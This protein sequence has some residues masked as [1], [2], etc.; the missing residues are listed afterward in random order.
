MLRKGC[1]ASSALVRHS[2][3][4]S[5]RNVGLGRLNHVA[6]AVP[7]LRTAAD[8]YRKALGAVVSEPQDLPAHG[9]RTVFV[10]LSNCDIELLEP[11]GES[12]PIARYLKKNPQGGMHHVCLEVAD[13]SAALKVAKSKGLKPVDPD[14][15]VKIGA[16]GN[17]VTF[18]H[19]Q[20]TC[21]TLIELEEVKNQEHL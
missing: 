13:I 10:R 15:E 9:V 5:D 7:C 1:T 2:S 20:S 8:V 3:S 18:F 11:L 14:N 16:H 21:G 4:T 12:S 6:L 17:P 19:P